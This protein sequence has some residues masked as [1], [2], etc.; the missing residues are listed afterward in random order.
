MNPLKSSFW[1]GGFEVREGK[2][3]E[4]EDLVPF[5][6]HSHRFMYAFLSSLISPNKVAVE[7][8][9]FERICASHKTVA[10]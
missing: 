10:I 7:A 6:P 3:K 8:K 9:S 2:S 4:K 5:R 1:G